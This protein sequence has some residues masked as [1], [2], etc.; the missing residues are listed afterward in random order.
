[1]ASQARIDG[2]LGSQREKGNDRRFSAMRG[3]MVSCRPVTPFT[4]G[5]LRRFFPA[6]HAFKVR[7]FVELEPDIRVACL[8]SH[9]SHVLLRVGLGLAQKDDNKQQQ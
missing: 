9:A 8:A 5:I 7:I 2:L 3:H 1:V 4:S 6:G